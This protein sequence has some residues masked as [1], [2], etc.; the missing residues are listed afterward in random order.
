MEIDTIKVGSEAFSVIP[1]IIL[2]IQTSTKLEYI[3]DS[4]YAIS[5]TYIKEDYLGLLYISK[6]RF[7]V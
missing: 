1:N 4:Y 3:T 5:L 2:N 6:D 7:K